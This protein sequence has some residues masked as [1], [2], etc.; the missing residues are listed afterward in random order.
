MRHDN[1]VFHAMLNHVPWHVFDRLVDEYGSDARVRRLSTKD[2][3]IALLY[4]QLSG[5]QSLREIEGGLASHAGRLYHLG[6]REVSR[7]TL[8]DANAKRPNAVF[9]GLFAD[10]VQ[11]A[12]RGLRRKLGEAVYLVDSTGLRLSEQSADW[13]QFSNDVCG[14]KLHIVYNADSEHPVD[15]V[16]TPA[17]INDITVAHT[18][19]IDAGATYVF[20]LGYYSYAWWAELDAQGCGIVTRLK[21]NTKLSVVETNPV[22]DETILSDCIGH[23]PARQAA[24]RSNPFQEPVREIRV[25]ID[26][27]KILRIVSN[28]LDAPA[29]EI[30]ALYK[31]RWQIELFFRW[32][33]QTLKIKHFLG[34]SE[35]AVRIQIAVALIAFLLLRLAHAT[36]RAVGS[37]LAFSR[38]VRSNLMHRRPI[39]ALLK[40][41]PI[42]QDQRQLSL[43]I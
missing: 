40:P 25:R 24:S 39:D 37:V 34:S 2:Q 33:K 23:L 18:L 16:V 41:P 17:R 28:D 29:A 22:K 43:A 14:A 7:S 5:A 13:A 11:R 6:G 31:R 38:L 3:L 9:A 30:A 21:S 15:A 42:I 8:A 19:P 36:Q 4:G 27:G 35:N 10:L 1:S 32:I 12:G 20:D 26:R